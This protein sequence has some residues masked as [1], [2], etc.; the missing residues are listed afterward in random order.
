MRE[1]VDM[2]AKAVKELDND[3]VRFET[4]CANGHFFF[5]YVATVTMAPPTNAPTMKDPRTHSTSDP[6]DMYICMTI[7]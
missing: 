2:P 5:L 7:S 3:Q 4:Y 1:I 6:K